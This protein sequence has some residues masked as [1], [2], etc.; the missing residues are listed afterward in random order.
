MLYFMIISGAFLVGVAVNSALMNTI[1]NLL[2]DTEEMEDT[3]NSFLKQMK[4]RYKNCMRIGHE[5][6]NTEAFAGKYMD[7]Y[8][9]YGLS[10]AAFEKII[11]VCGAVCV[12]TAIAGAMLDRSRLMQYLLLGFLAMY[13][14]NGLKNMADIRG[15][16]KRI[17]RNI[18]DFFEN[19]FV[20]VTE[21]SRTRYE[22]PTAKN[23]VKEEKK[24]EKSFTDEEKRIIDDILREYLG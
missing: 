12:I 1:R 10:F 14:I 9:N 23:V 13:V 17:T 16:R 18:V 5:I 2:R 3:D 24:V 22:E 8:T 4:L 15:N 19:R 20:A 21:E 6:R 11:S 7:K